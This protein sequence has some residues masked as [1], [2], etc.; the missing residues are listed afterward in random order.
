MKRVFLTLAIAYSIGNYAFSQE[1]AENNRI[2]IAKCID[3]M[4]GK[5]KTTS[6][7]KLSGSYDNFVIYPSYEHPS[8]Y[9][10]RIKISNYSN[11]RKAKKQHRNSKGWYEYSGVVEYF[12]TDYDARCQEFDISTWPECHLTKK[13]NCVCYNDAVW[14]DEK[15]VKVNQKPAIIKIA[16]Y[17][18][19][20]RC[21][22]IYFNNIGIGISIDSSMF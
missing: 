3:A 10:M 21:Y 6:T 18:G 14:V 20:P 11:D 5:W 17:N 15:Y 4:W 7:Y 1:I 16:P 22:N 2:E 19:V 13:G 12:T 9:I 8:K